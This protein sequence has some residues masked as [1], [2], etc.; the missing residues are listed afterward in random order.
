[1]YEWSSSSATIENPVEEDWDEEIRRE[2]EQRKQ[3]KL[4]K[5]IWLSKQRQWLNIRKD[6]VWKKDIRE[7]I[8]VEQ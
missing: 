8:P 4:G 3:H 5:E 2:E 1:M 6:K 7:R